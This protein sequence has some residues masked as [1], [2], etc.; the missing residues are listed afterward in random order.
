MKLLDSHIVVRDI[1]FVSQKEQ[2]LRS[3]SQVCEYLKIVKDS[4]SNNEGLVACLAPVLPFAPR[5]ASCYVWLRAWYTTSHPGF[6][7]NPSRFVFLKS[8][9]HVGK[10]SLRSPQPPCAASIVSSPFPSRRL[11]LYITRAEQLH[12]IVLNI[13]LTVKTS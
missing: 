7:G 8:L 2:Y 1:P 6:F 9:I 13:F 3:K 4:C 11:C 10:W 12:I 5:K